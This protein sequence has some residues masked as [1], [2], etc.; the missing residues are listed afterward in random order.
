MKLEDLLRQNRTIRVIGFD[1]APFLRGAGGKVAIAG[2][3]CAGTRFEGMLWGEVTQDGFDATDTLCEL[4]IGSKFLP[5]LHLVLLDGIGFGGFNLVDLPRLQ[6]R[7]QLPCVAVMRRHPRL[8]PMKE[9]MSRLPHFER[10]LSILQRAGAIYHVPP[11]FF[12]VCGEDPAIAAS[13]LQ[14]VTD[15]G[16][17]PEALRLAHLIGAAVVTGV[18]GSSA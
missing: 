15:C 8:P 11:F 7:L 2:V 10:R 5:Q 13:A 4:L 9:A 1:D 14:R 6:D 12:Q 18:S 17:V 16:K 3:V